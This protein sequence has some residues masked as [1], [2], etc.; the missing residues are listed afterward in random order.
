[1]KFPVA[2]GK[3]RYARLDLRRTFTDTY[4]QV[5]F[6]EHVR[7]CPYAM[8]SLSLFFV[9]IRFFQGDERRF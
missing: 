4:G 6:P 9:K 8:R 5:D 1:L 3:T 2:D 7:F